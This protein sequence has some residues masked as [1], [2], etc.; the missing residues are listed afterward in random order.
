MFYFM[1][2]HTCVCHVPINNTY[3][4]KK[5]FISTERHNTLCPERPLEKRIGRVANAI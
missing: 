5:V 1:Y 4:L 3:L 2:Y